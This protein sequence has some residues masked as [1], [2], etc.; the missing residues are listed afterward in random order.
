MNVPEPV[1]WFDVPPLVRAMRAV[2]DVNFVGTEDS[3]GAIREW[4]ATPV[5]Y[6]QP[7][8]TSGRDDGQCF[9]VTFKRT[10]DSPAGLKVGDVVTVNHW[11]G[12]GT[13]FLSQM[14]RVVAIRRDESTVGVFPTGDWNGRKEHLAIRVAHS[15]PHG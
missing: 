6:M 9:M 2:W 14:C 4:G 15:V 12:N 1:E 5:Y 11:R 8:D 13:L 10:S 7:L 3:G